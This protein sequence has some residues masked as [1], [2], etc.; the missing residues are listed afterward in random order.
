MFFHFAA[1]THQRNNEYKVL[2]HGN[3]AEVMLSFLT[4][5][6]WQG[7][8]CQR[9]YCLFKSIE[10]LLKLLSQ[11][12]ESAGDTAFRYIIPTYGLQ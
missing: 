8:A 7:L 2:T 5:Y 6:P 12:V 11:W 1:R 9:Y 3:L 10:T 4:K